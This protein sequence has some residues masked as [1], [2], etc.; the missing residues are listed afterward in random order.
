M[1][2][3]K[4][5]ADLGVNPSAVYS[6]MAS[7]AS[8]PRQNLLGISQGDKDPLTT[9]NRM[10]NAYQDYSGTAKYNAQMQKN[11]LNQSLIANS[12]W[13]TGRWMIPSSDEVGWNA[14]SAWRNRPQDSGA[15][16]TQ[17]QP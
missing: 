5:Y 6:R 2:L 9:M 12:P 15:N 8:D 17:A 1:G 14:L 16:T 4:R 10:V 13:A 7:V 11:D 3:A